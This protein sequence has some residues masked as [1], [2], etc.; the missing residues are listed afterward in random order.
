MGDVA[1]VLGGGGLLGACEAGMARA[2]AEAGIRPDR[3]FGTSIGAIN[4]AMIAC[5]PSISG[6]RALVDMWDK[7]SA[8]DVLGGSLL[9]RLGELVRNRT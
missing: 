4:G 5:D 3:V 2:L 7:L 6:S 1:F 8:D 9:G